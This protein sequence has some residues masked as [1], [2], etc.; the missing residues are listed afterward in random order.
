MRP[1]EKV[2][3]IYHPANGRQMNVGIFSDCY[4][5]TLNGVSTAIAQVRAELVRRGHR[6][7]VFT[8]AAPGDSGAPDRCGPVHR[9]P[10]LP[11]NPQIQ[12][13]I[14]LPWQRSIDRAVAAEQIDVIHTHTEFSLGRAGQA[15]AASLGVPAVHTLHT[16][17]PAYRHYLPLGRLL[18]RRAVDVIVA[19]FLRRCDAVVCPSEKGQ[20]YVKGCAPF[21]ATRVIP[22]GILPGRFCPD[23]PG[24]ALR[25]S[26]RAVLG[27]GPGER[28]VLYAGRLA[29]EKRVLAL[30]DAL[31]P[32]LAS[33]PCVRAVFAGAGPQAVALAAAARSLRLDQPVLL[34]GPVRWE[35]MPRL[36]ALA[37]VFAT[38]SLSEIHP[39]TLIEAAAS[40]LPAVARTDPSMTGLILD[41][42]N[43]FLVDSDADITDRLAELLHDDDTRRA[44]G[45][46]AAALSARLTVCAHVDRLEA[47][48]RHTIETYPR[49][50]AR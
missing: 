7:T 50:A 43:G 10:S 39:M 44:S 6:V 49:K 42:F 2:G 16:F 18:P 26:G 40:G 32:L 19:R 36:Y 20:A 25:A 3:R 45:L 30:L 24:G 37:D 1:T 48:Y 13:R 41:G 8:V 28:V 31:R 27:L 5:P 33:D 15:A 12:L 21:A 34:P 47:L 17:Y 22:N 35:D 9:V 46:N 14:G 38:A 4:L 11:F 29:P 23:Q